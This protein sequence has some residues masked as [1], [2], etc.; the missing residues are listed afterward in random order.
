MEQRHCPSCGAIIL[1]AASWLIWAGLVILSV[2]G[3]MVSAGWALLGWLL[4][5][6][7]LP[8]VPAVEPAARAQLTVTW[9]EISLAGQAL[10]EVVAIVATCALVRTER[11][12]PHGCV[13]CGWVSQDSAQAT[14]LRQWLSPQHSSQPY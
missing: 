6:S 3:A 11:V 1:G 2:L 7:G 4:L 10:F 14:R 12:G 5:H 8:L 9:L 13:A